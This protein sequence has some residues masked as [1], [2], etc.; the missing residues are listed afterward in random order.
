[1]STYSVP[2]FSHEGCIFVVDKAR[3]LQ[4]P[5]VL[6]VLSPPWP[7]WPVRLP[8][9]YVNV[10]HRCC[11]RCHFGWLCDLL[12]SDIHSWERQ[13]QAVGSISRV[14]KK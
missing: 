14:F 9:P 7:H 1:M 8:I 11:W 4:D 13:R 6:A 10:L 3:V 5:A 2:E 12:C